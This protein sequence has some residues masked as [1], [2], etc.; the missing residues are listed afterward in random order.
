MKKEKVSIYG[1]SFEN[2]V[3]SFNLR[4]TM[5]FDYYRVNNQIQDLNKEYNMQHIAIPADILPDNNEEIVVMY[6]YVERYVKHY[7]SDFYVLDML[8]YFKFN[9]KVIWVL[10]DNGT[11]M[12]GVENEDTIMIL[13]HYADRCKAIF[14][15]DNGRFKKISLNKAIQIS[16]KSKITSN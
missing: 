4:V 16:N 11:N 9:C 3:P 6:R 10:R 7:K 2:G 12:I 5:E 14:L 8:T 1:L 13:E 15:I